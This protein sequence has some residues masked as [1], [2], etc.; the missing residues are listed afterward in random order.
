MSVDYTLITKDEL[1]VNSLEKKA[2]EEPRLSPIPDISGKLEGFQIEHTDSAEVLPVYLVFVKTGL[3]EYRV[4]C[5]TYTQSALEQIRDTALLLD[6]KI[7]DH[8]TDKLL[9]PSELINEE[10]LNY[11]SIMQNTKNSMP[12]ILGGSLPDEPLSE[13]EIQ[14]EKEADEMFQKRLDE[15]KMVVGQIKKIIKMDKENSLKRAKKIIDPNYAQTI[16]STPIGGLPQK[17]EDNFLMITNIK[18]VKEFIFKYISENHKEN[19]DIYQ[20]RLF[21]E[22]V[23]ADLFREEKL[24]LS[25]RPGLSNY[26]SLALCNYIFFSY[27]NDNYEKYKINKDH[28]S[29]SLTMLEEDESLF[30]EPGND[31]PFLVAADWMVAYLCD[32]IHFTSEQLDDA[33][34]SS[35]LN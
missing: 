24:V 2:E 20:L 17:L 31:D 15:L 28:L 16:R 30:G 11:I 19:P 33:D 21:V 3:K 10:T 7:Y 8:Q 22:G 27:I 34:T 4:G 26:E 29:I 12:Q 32:S 14:K 35:N 18:E 1:T 9:I 5:Y 6:A 25:I 13:E 23:S